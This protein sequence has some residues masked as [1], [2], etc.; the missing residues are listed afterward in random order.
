MHRSDVVEA[1]A[2]LRRDEVVVVGPG[3]ASGAL[4][5]AGHLPATVYN[6]EM[7]YPSAVCLGI[8]LGDP[9]L[10]VVAV[11]GDGSLLAGMGVLSTIARYRPANLVILV[12]DNRRYAS[13]GT[14]W[15]S[16]ATDRGTDLAAVA[17]AC[18]IAAERVLDVSDVDSTGA[19]LETALAGGGPWV[20]V[21]KVEPVDA[22]PGGRAPL[23][24]YDFV[25]TSV[26]LRRELIR[27]R[28]ERT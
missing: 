21:A 5:E 17:R 23:P 16:T 1:L 24:G 14:G 22:W 27:R 11:E 26:S 25:E 19:A 7:G 28:R 9:A 6:M 18:G 4:Y 12:L 20:V 10:P 3:S 13:C 8:A 15:A 2:K